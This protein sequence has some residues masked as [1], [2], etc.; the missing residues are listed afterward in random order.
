MR[1]LEPDLAKEFHPEMN[2]EG[3]NPETL[4]A[5]TNK[6]IWWICNTISD[7]PCG[8]IWLATGNKRVSSERRGCPR[9]AK[10][11]FKSDEPGFLYCLEMDGP[12]GKFWKVGITNNIE[13]RLRQIETSIRSTTLYNDYKI[14]VYN[15]IEFDKGWKARNMEQSFL[16][17]KEIRY[18]PDEEFSGSTE[19]FNQ[20]PDVF[21]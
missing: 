16:Q 14:S 15:S 18:V 2:E 3:M 20:I 5:G 4:I 8:Y 21:L 13:R 19:L 7:S 6:K 11:G 9:C 17:K 10:Y 1:K 12:L